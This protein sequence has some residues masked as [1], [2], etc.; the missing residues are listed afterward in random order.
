MQVGDVGVGDIV[1]WRQLR[2]DGTFRGP[3]HPGYVMCVVRKGEVDPHHLNESVATDDRFW[4][5]W[6]DHNGVWN[7]RLS[8][9][10]ISRCFLPRNARRL[11]AEFIGRW[12][13]GEVVSD[14]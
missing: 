14:I 12:M 7:L 5:Y 4:C 10:P 8:Y 13:R 6:R 3:V 11:R 9:M 2:L 1:A